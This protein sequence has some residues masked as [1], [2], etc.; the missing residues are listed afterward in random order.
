MSDRARAAADAPS[1]FVSQM[2]EMP[3][4]QRAAQQL[5]DRVRS[6]HTPLD[7][8]LIPAAN[9]GDRGQDVSKGD[10][11]SFLDAFSATKTA[12][13]DNNGN[14]HQVDKVPGADTS[15]RIFV[16]P[17]NGVKAF[18]PVGN[19]TLA[20]SGGG[21]GSLSVRLS[22]SKKRSLPPT[23]EEGELTGQWDGVAF[24]GS[25]QSAKQQAAAELAVQM[26][27]GTK[28]ASGRLHSMIKCDVEIDVAEKE[29][30][31]PS[32]FSRKASV[33]GMVE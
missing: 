7:V 22:L 4:V 16:P 20:A 27:W 6:A 31:V 8:S 26:W 15:M 2:R 32:K 14:R 18:S 17:R 12:T 11:E 13:M 29:G 19:R 5:S 33:L 1:A 9:I 10:K 21:D 23:E 3:E 28:F 30:G 24:M 25:S